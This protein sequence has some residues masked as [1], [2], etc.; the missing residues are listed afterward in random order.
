M[1]LIIHI[2]GGSRGNPGPAACAFVIHDTDSNQV[3]REEGR[4]LGRLTN[5]VAEYTGLV[6]AIEAAVELNPDSVHIHSDSELMV[7]QILGEYR[8]KSE[9]LKPL[10]AKALAGLRRLKS[11]RMTH[12]RREKNRRADELVNMALDRQANVRHGDAS[13]AAPTSSEPLFW[14]VRLESRP[15]DCPADC[16]ETKSYVFGP[17]L[18]EGFCLDAARDL[19]PHLSASS[20]DPRPIK[21]RRCGVAMRVRCEGR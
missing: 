2:D 14:T 7:K 5:N 15:R 12:V 19:L 3:V 8:V 1:N 6:C 18:P 20:R 16:D 21:C 10:H 11:W 9:D 13:Q 4:F 17:H